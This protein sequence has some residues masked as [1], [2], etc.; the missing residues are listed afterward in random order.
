MNFRRDL[1]VP[2]VD[3]DGI[4][5]GLKALCCLD[6]RGHGSASR[7][8]ATPRRAAGRDHPLGSLLHN[9]VPKRRQPLTPS[10][11]TGGTLAHAT[12]TELIWIKAC[13]RGGR[14]IDLTFVHAPRRSPVELVDNR[15]AAAHQ[16]QSF[17][18]QGVLM[19]RFSWLWSQ[20]APNPADGSKPLAAR[21]SHIEVVIRRSVSPAPN[22]AGVRFL[23]APAGSQ[24]TSSARGSTSTPQPAGSAAPSA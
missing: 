7:W 8:V 18:A 24:P 13:V 23:H 4:A 6:G 1:T 11:E 16:T 12:S 10:K 14:E 15:L 17:R 3:F 21:A 2:H 19:D 20:P 22:L 9:I 5:F